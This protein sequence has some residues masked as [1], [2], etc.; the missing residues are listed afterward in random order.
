[1]PSSTTYLPPSGAVGA[2]KYTHPTDRERTA[3]RPSKRDA[4]GPSVATTTLLP[5]T[6]SP[7]VRRTLVP[8]TAAT[9]VFN[10]T[11]PGARPAAICAGMAPIPAAGTA[12]SPS[13]SMRKMM[14]NMRALVDSAGSSWIPPN[15]GRKKRSMMVSLNPWARNAS[16]VGRSVPR[17]RAAASP[18]RTRWR[19]RTMRALSMGE[20]ME[21]SALDANVPGRRNG[22]P[23]TR[24]RV[25]RHTMAPG[26]NVCR[27]SAAMSSWRGSSGYAVSNTWNPRSSRNPSTSSVR[28]RPPTPSLASSRHTLRPA[29]CSVRAAASPAKPAPTITA[30]KPSV[31]SPASRAAPPR[32][33]GA[34]IRSRWP[35][36][37]RASHAGR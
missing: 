18:R 11:V 1:M 20:P 16:M 15:R 13:L 24:P 32:A 22:S 34:G 31:I 8:S 9:G 6:T 29:A 3:G 12:E 5:L 35:A 17:S 10:R 4:A 23:T 27:F 7:L 33:W 25:P 19:R 37:R 14:S 36:M 30:S 28:T 2:A 21:A 26:S